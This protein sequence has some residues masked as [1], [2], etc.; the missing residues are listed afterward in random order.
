MNKLVLFLN[1]YATLRYAFAALLLLQIT[2]QA[3]Q[4][5]DQPLVALSPNEGKLDYHRLYDVSTVNRIYEAYGPRGRLIYALDLVVDT[6]FPVL[7]SLSTILFGL[8]AVRQ[9]L[10]QKLFI[11]IPLVL[12]IADG[13]EN[14]FFLYFLWRFPVIPVQPVT[15]ANLFTRIKL[16]A[17]PITWLELYLFV[18]LYIL[19]FTAQEMRGL[20]RS[21]AISW[22]DRLSE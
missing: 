6:V 4:R 11:L 7:L 21:E 8:L 12:I 18:I 10:L 5:L 1:R 13:M 22:G 3:L 16:F 2:I 17:M 9:T 14:N 19:I 20:K 15:V